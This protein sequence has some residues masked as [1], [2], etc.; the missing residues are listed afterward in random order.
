VGRVAPEAGVQVARPCQPAGP[1]TR[2]GCLTGRA[3]VSSCCQASSGS[4]L[5]RCCRRASNAPQSQRTRR[6]NSLWAGSRG[7]EWTQS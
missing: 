4:R 2:R 7:K 3:V 5:T 1:R 6:L